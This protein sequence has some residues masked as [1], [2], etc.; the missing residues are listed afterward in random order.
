KGTI[1]RQET[2]LA[3]KR[4]ARKIYRV[5]GEVFPYAH[6]ELDFSNPFELLVATVRSEEHTSELQSRFEL[7]CRL[8]LA[9]KKRRRSPQRARRRRPAAVTLPTARPVRASAQD[10]PQPRGAGD[11]G[12]GLKPTPQAVGRRRVMGV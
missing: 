12:F 1:M 5:L 4:R 8:L 3:K 2:P 10:W 6:A 7:V 9:K 11:S